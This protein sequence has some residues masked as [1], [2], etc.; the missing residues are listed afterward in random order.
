MGMCSI[1]VC[2][3]RPRQSE[4]LELNSAGSRLYSDPGTYTRAQT[5]CRTLHFTIQAVRRP[6]AYMFSIIQNFVHRT[7]QS[8]RQMCN[9]S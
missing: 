6:Y 9:T 8:V 5:L 1:E 4:K 7:R 3:P 2:V